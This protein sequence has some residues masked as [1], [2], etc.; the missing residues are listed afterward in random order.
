MRKE[1]REELG[2]TYSPST[3][4]QPSDTFPEYGNL[5]GFSIAKPDDLQKIN[6]LT[7]ELAADFSENGADKDE[8]ER[9]LK[10]ALSELEKSLRDNSY[11]LNTVLSRS[12]A[13]PQRLEWARERD[14]DYRS[15]S[16]SDINDLAKQYLGAHNAIRFQLKPETLP[17]EE[18]AED[19]GE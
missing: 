14:K 3:G 5:I 9:A 13:E 17:S 10:P 12:Q 2:A 16:L 1:I 11:W 6:D 8:L 18:A 15:I 4:S 7:I 19:N